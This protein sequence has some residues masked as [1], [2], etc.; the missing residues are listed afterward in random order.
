MSVDTIGPIMSMPSYLICV[1]RIFFLLK[2]GRNMLRFRWCVDISGTQF[3][4]VNERCLDWIWKRARSHFGNQNCAF[5]GG[6]LNFLHE[7]FNF[8]IYIYLPGGIFDVIGSTS[9]PATTTTTT[10]KP[11]N[12]IQ[13]K[14]IR[15]TCLCIWQY[16]GIIFRIFALS[17]THTHKHTR[18]KYT[19]AA[20]I[21]I[22]YDWPIQIR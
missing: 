7:V 12:H 8:S 15:I 3:I 16:L 6:K 1:W 21:T 17:V 4:F 22:D 13:S 14:W 10:K 9:R 18:S 2:S 11:A 20:G 5:C 19:K